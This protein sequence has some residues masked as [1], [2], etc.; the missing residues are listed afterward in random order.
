MDLLFVSPWNC[1]SGGHLYPSSSLLQQLD[2]IHRNVLPFTK[3]IMYGSTILQWLSAVPG[4]SPGTCMWSASLF[5]SGSV[6]F[7]SLFSYCSSSSLSPPL[8]SIESHQFI[9]RTILC[10][11][12]WASISLLHLDNSHFS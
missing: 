10:A 7:S 3:S 9:E 5:I 2:L 8:S 6:S 4:S 11:K 12:I 1:I